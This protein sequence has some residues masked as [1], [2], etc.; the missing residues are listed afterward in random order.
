MNFDDILKGS[1]ITEKLN[2]A[3]DI[4]PTTLPDGFQMTN[5]ADKGAATVKE[6]TRSN[7]VTR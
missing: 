5:F 1:G 4:P 3:M 2:Q 6:V 7:G